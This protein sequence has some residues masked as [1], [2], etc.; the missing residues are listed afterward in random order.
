MQP[1]KRLL[2]IEEKIISC[3]PDSCSVGFSFNH[4]IHSTLYKITLST[5]HCPFSTFQLNPCFLWGSNLRKQ[6][7]PRAGRMPPSLG[8]ALFKAIYTIYFCAFDSNTTDSTCSLLSKPIFK[9]SSMIGSLKVIDFS[10]CPFGCF[11]S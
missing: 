8:N 9:S 10:H 4:S 7:N 11:S 6:K 1:R 3:Q 5:Q 2:D